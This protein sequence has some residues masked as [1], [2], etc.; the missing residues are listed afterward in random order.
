[1][2]GA[3]SQLDPLERHLLELKQAERDG[4]FSRTRVDDRMLRT[5]EPDVNPTLRLGVMRRWGTVAAAVVLVVGVWSAM[6]TF[7]IH[8]VRRSRHIVENRGGGAA[9]VIAPGDILRCI[10]GPSEPAGNQCRRHDYDSDGDVDLA[11]FQS[12]QLAYAGPAAGR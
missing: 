10:G 8:D 9:R 7:K 11:D 2:N 1:M 4:V 12:Y 6:F 5:P 3:E